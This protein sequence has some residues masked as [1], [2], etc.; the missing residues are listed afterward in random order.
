MTRKDYE[1]ELRRQREASRA[2]YLE[3]N[4]TAGNDR[5]AHA[6]ALGYRSGLEVR[7]AQQLEDLGVNFGY[8][9]HVVRY[10]KPARLAKY[11]PDLMLPNGIV[12][13]TK[14]RFDTA[15]RQK[16]L[17][18]KEQHPDLDIRFVFSNPNTRIS[19][20]SRTTYAMWCDKHGF[21][22]AKGNIPS[23]WISEPYD[24]RRVEAIYEAGLKP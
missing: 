17:L 14:G 5:Y 11:T 16:H 23:D 21:T 7:V 9:T 18:I 6:R 24:Q 8:E 19:K 4:P 10:V 3:L 2:R 12:I 22:Y 15:D 13:E 20:Q 1:S